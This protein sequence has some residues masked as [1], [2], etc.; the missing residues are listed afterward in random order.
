[1]FS[2]RY[3]Q[4]IFEALK[5]IIKWTIKFKIQNKIYKSNYEA[6]IDS[7][8]KVNIIKPFPYLCVAIR[9][10]ISSKTPN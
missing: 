5:K 6:N 10:E 7:E 8:H 3:F 1:M 2:D 9:I 4:S